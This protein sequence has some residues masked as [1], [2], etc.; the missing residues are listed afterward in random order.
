MAA[1]LDDGVYSGVGESI[2]GSEPLTR[3][4][5]SPSREDDGF[6]WFDSYGTEDES[7][8]IWDRMPHQELGRWMTHRTLRLAGF[9]FE[10]PRTFTP[11]CQR[12]ER[13]LA[14]PSRPTPGMTTVEWR[15]LDG[16][17]VPGNQRRYIDGQ[18]HLGAIA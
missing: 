14:P 5:A 1:R 12:D 10:A 9:G 4:R 16:A 6:V 18:H 8:D 11:T 2:N 3:Q 17:F 13:S 15:Q 7:G